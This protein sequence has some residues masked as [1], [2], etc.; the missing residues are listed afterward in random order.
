M[1]L[2]AAPAFAQAVPADQSA[3]TPGSESDELVV[4]EITV[5]AERIRGQ[6][7]VPQAPVAT[8]DEAQ[9]QAVGASS[10]SDLLAAIAPQTG[11]G[12]G[13]GGGGPIVLVNGQRI[14]SF[15]ELRNYPP[16]AI[17][18]VEVMP[19]EVA[20]RLGYPANAR[21]VNMI[22]KEN[23]A[24]RRVELEYGVPTLGGFDEWQAQ[25]TLLKIDGANRFSVSLSAEDRSPLFEA[26]RGIVQPADPAS[27]E[28]RSLIADSRELSVNGSWT[29][30]L[31]DKG[32]NG[33]LS[34]NAT[35][36]RAD[37]HSYSGL[38]PVNRMVLDRIGRTDTLQGGAGYNR[39]L[40]EWRLNATLDAGHA[41][42]TQRIERGDGSAVF[43]RNRAVNDS[44]GSLVTLT[45]KPLRLPAGEAALTVRGGYVW[46]SIRSSDTRSAAEPVT[47]R[48]GDLSAG[49]SLAVPIASR[50]ESVLDA[51][52]DLSLDLSAGLNHL[53]DFGTL[54][55]WSAGLTWSPTERLTLSASYLVN[56]A[57]PSL[58]QLGNPFTVTPNVPVF[59][60]ANGETV[61]ASVTTGGNPAL[62]KERQRDWKLSASW[63]VPGLPNATL[64]TE[65]FR[66][67]SD[68]V[69]AA[70]PLLTPEVEDAFDGRVTR[71][72]DG[73]IVA[74][75]L[76]PV[77]FARQTGSRLRWG[78]NMSGSIGGN[79]V[80]E[81]GGRVARD[82]GNPRGPGTPGGFGGRGGG[83]GGMMGRLMGGNA[84]GRWNVGAYHT[85]QFDS[86]VL[87]AP[88]GPVLDLLGGD[89]LS[90]SGTP[91][92]AIEFNGGAAYRGKGIFLN[93]TWNA[94]TRVTTPTSD[95]RFGA[96]TKVG[97]NLFVNLGEQGKLADD[98]P[99]LKDT[100]L[101]LRFE[102][103]FN[104]RQKVT[105][106]NGVV[107][108]GYSRDYL[109]P[110]GRVIELELRKMF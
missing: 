12:R 1:L 57:A 89:A 13:R 91:R 23:F 15:R 21:V 19:E 31:G 9:I 54:T 77:T 79:G 17:R 28:Y 110:R 74:V 46:S 101:S 70:F 80:R 103:L 4:N 22:L 3:E 39:P 8:F 107:P 81:A 25:G 73:R 26:E 65:Y 108:L 71:G 59:D 61:L 62:L 40:G 88:G 53:S 43:D 78:L 106:A 38:D 95:L 72:P 58:G 105:D 82:R 11:S 92:H 83:G 69:S 49:L 86:K 109:D 47:L 96:V 18:K 68:N 29:R 48:R 50:R 32:A 51:I 63:N 30:G 99:F 66:N 84:G 85:V 33:S 41:V 90:A 45:G 102:N 67:R 36:T 64:V 98:A 24:S 60:F 94:P 42:T 10:V 16:E 14:S 34:L 55:D 35:L 76:R 75:D 44:L 93:G 56:S 20:L 52:G 37:T 5:V 104:S 97:V 100:R 87:I 27:S 2:I 7:D 6:L